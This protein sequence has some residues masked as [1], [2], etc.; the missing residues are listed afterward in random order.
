MFYTRCQPLS[1]GLSVGSLDFS[2][3]SLDFFVGS[4]DFYAG[5]LSRLGAYSGVG[6]SGE[7]TPAPP[8]EKPHSMGVLRVLGVTSVG[9]AG[10]FSFI[11]IYTILLP[12]H[13]RIAYYRRHSG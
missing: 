4:L 9:S 8:T 6:L 11:I 13:Y 12:L 5:H 3:G 2:V 1:L 10:Y 7:A